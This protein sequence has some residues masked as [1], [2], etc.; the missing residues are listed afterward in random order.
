MNDMSIRTSVS[1]PITRD[2]QVAGAN[3]PTSGTTSSM[4]PDPMSALLSSGD[5]GAMVA[6]LV[7]KSGQAQRAVRDQ[8]RRSEDAVQDA[9]EK[10]QVANMR[11][12]AKAMENS[13]VMMGVMTMAS[14]ACAAAGSKP[15]ADIMDGIGKSV[16]GFYDAEVKSLEAR[17]TED[18]HRAARAERNVK[19]AD[20][21]IDDANR[22]IDKAL[23]FYKE[24]TSGKNQAVQAATHRA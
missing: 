4:L 1:S 11:A 10:S 2:D 12:Q 5:P 18:E 22:L 6:A 24:Y 3:T 7:A 21:G 13:A 23:E 14:G 9:A 20:E 19:N 8:V 15:G 17:A 16:A